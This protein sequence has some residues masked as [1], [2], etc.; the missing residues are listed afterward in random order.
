MYSEKLE[1]LISLVLSDGIL[2]EQKRDIIKRRAEKEGEDVDEV[3]MI[4]ESRLQKQTPQF[5]ETELYREETHSEP[6]EPDY[7]LIVPEN[8]MKK[9][10]KI[11]DGYNK[12]AE[13][14]G[15]EVLRFH[16]F[17][18]TIDGRFTPKTD[19]EDSKAGFMAEMKEAYKNGDLEEEWKKIL[20][21][22]NRMDLCK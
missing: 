16:S 19:A 15:Y 18:H 22:C 17:T 13:K 9:V 3:M 2:T 12:K 8:V 1:E 21:L 11:M 7:N 6:V 14:W 5:T 20:K 10:L 4:V